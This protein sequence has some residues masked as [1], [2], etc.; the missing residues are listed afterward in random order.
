MFMRYIYIACRSICIVLL[1]T[2]VQ[3]LHHPSHVL[4]IYT[5]PILNSKDGTIQGILTTRDLQE[6]LRPASERG[7]KQQ[8]LRDLS[9][10][11]GKTATSMAEPPLLH[12]DYDGASRESRNHHNNTSNTSLAQ[13]HHHREHVWVDAQQ[14]QP[15][16]VTIGAAE[17]PHP[18]KTPSGSSERGK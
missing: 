11:V 5:Q 8:Y 4:L 7:G 9:D 13:D 14:Q 12:G 17:L 6:Y 16:Y 2:Y 15:L 10:R 3:H 18:Y 1:R